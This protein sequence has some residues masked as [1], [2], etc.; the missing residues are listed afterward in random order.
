MLWQKIKYD[1]LSWEAYSSYKNLS[2]EL[3][4]IL[5]GIGSLYNITFA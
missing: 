3:E 4:L 1:W 5:A 2:Q